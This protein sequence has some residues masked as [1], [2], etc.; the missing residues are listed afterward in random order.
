MRSSCHIWLLAGNEVSK[1]PSGNFMSSAAQKAHR[2]ILTAS[3]I[4]TV[5]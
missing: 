1:T 4:A 3:A 2:V 5:F